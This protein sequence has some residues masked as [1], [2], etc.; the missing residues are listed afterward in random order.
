MLFDT[1][2]H[3]DLFTEPKKLIE[4]VEN[5]KMYTIAVT[6]LPQVF[7][8]TQKLC[9]GLKYIRP[10]L[11]YHPELAF[12]FSNQ[13]D[14]FLELIDQTRYIGEIGLDNQRKTIEDFTS[15]KK[16]FE[17]IISVCR[18]RKDKILTVHSRRAEKEVV[19]IIGNNFPGKVILHWYSGS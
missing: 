13:F 15:Q 5:Q 9:E 19:S 11:G 16:I 17:N 2:L 14:L 12:K 7:L 8:N 3:L 6:N 1:H 18:E 10:A 4:A